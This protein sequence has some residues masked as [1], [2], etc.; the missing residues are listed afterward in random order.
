[1]IEF[2]GR[3]HVFEFDR[4]SIPY[5]SPSTNYTTDE[6][7]YLYKCRNCGETGWSLAFGSKKYKGDLIFAG[8]GRSF[9]LKYPKIHCPSPKA[10]LIWFFDLHNNNCLVDKRRLF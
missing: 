5:P 3:F 1:M 6:Q 4:M 2:M 9:R 7:C 10:P 8:A